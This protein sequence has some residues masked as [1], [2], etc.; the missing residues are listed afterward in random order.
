MD[1][2]CQ[3]SLPFAPWM[4]APSRRLPGVQPVPLEDW[5]QLDDA[6]AG[7][8]AR[9]IQLLQ[10]ER[11]QVLAAPAD[12]LVPC[13]ELL[14][15]VLRQ[16]PG[17]GFD[18]GQK[19]NCPD[20]RIVSIDYDAPL[21]T[22]CHLVQ[23]DFCLL[24]PEGGAHVLKA[25]VLCFPASWSLHEK[26]GHPLLAIHAPVASYGADLNKRVERLFTAAKP[27]R[28]LMRANALIYGD[29]ELFHPRRNSDPPRQ[30]GSADFIRS[31][32]QTILRLPRSGAVVFSIHT[33][34]VRKEDLTEEQRAGLRRY[35]IEPVQRLD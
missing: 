3:S 9:R 7:Q 22:L 10:K 18:C 34:V 4:W 13:R 31:E 14:D 15:L 24:V 16:L 1:Q 17:L 5:L 20:G 30:H 28:P 19:I 21:E 27:G 12:M 26:L 11:A 8:M 33:Y 29:A 6:Y 23:E 32:R 35:P 2:I 25:A